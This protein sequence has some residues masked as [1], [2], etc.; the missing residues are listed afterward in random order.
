MAKGSKALQPADFEKA[1]EERRIGAW[2]AQAPWFR[3]G[4]IAGSWF[5]GLDG[6]FAPWVG[7][8]IKS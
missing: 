3:S 1:M 8:L 6:Q 5:I 2:C 4:H 7:T